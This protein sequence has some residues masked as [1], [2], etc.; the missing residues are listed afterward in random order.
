MKFRQIRRNFAPQTSYVGKRSGM[1]RG[2]QEAEE[3]WNFGAFR[4]VC[5]GRGGSLA[6]Q[7]VEDQSWGFIT[8]R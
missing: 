3:R 5:R 7:G 4:K 1:V 2:Y 8:G 6:F